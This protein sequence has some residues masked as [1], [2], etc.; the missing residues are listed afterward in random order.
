MGSDGRARRSGRRGRPSIFVRPVGS[1]LLRILMLRLVEL[2][3]ARAGL[4]HTWSSDSPYLARLLRTVALNLPTLRLQRRSFEAM[5][6]L[7]TEGERDVLCA[8]VKRSSAAPPAQPALELS[9]VRLHPAT[10]RL[11]RDLWLSSD[12][13]SYSPPRILRPL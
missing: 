2:L 12:A 10:S 8:L 13:L 7:T 6:Y 11:I 4:L 5:A 3:H 9:L 1:H